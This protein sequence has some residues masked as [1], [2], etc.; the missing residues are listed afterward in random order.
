[1]KIYV[2]NLLVQID[3]SAT[4]S[5]APVYTSIAIYFISIAYTTTTMHTQ[6][7]RSILGDQQS[8]PSYLSARPL[9]EQLEQLYEAK[10]YVASAPSCHL[11]GRTGNL[12][13]EAED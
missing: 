1:M 5:Y 10:E 8:C 11:I 7:S 6:A 12:W 13:P 3:T 9:Q 4:S 2:N